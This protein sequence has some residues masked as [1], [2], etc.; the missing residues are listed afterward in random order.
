MENIIEVKNLKKEFGKLAAV[1]DLTF[2]V[3]QGEIFGLIGPDGAGK[4]TTLR[5]L[6]GLMIPSSGIAAVMGMN[7]PREA[8]ALKERIGYMSQKFNLYSD[9]TVQ[10]NINFFAE[11]LQIDKQTLDKR[12]E[13]LFEMT[14]LKSFRN[15]LAGNLSGGMK[16]KLALICTLI[17]RPRLLLLDEPTTGVD[18]VSRSEFWEILHEMVLDGVTIVI[19]TPYMDEAEWCSRIGLMFEGRIISCDTPRKLKDNFRG[20]VIEIIPR[21]K[22]EEFISIIKEC[23]GMVDF[24]LLGRKY[25]LIMQDKSYADK[26]ESLISGRADFKI[27]PASI[28]DVFME[29]LKS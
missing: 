7:L 29:K 5:M 2:E 14:R 22:T 16:Q 17:H 24:Q 15:K 12:L 28:E 9:L 18:P 13:P 3:K 21:G 11:I 6:S 19:T 1:D 23:K 25:R 8:E 4:T 27:V 26:L 20:I 10:E